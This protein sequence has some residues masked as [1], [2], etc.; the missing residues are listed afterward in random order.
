MD[1]ADLDALNAEI[2]AGTNDPHFDLNSDDIV[3]VADRT[4][5]ITDIKNT[6]PGDTNLDGQV[7]SLDLNSLALSWRKVDATSWSQGDFNG[8]AENGDTYLSSFR[9][10]TGKTGENGGENGDTHLSSFRGQR[11][12]W[13]HASFGAGGH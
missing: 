3:D 4:I 2:R 11:G 7:D 5:W 8:E 10:T 1:V 9:R 13:T 12:K 6:F